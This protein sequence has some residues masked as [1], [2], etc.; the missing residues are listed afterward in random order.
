MKD[1]VSTPASDPAAPYCKKDI[2]VPEREKN[3][4]AGEGSGA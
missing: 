4:G 2:E 3:N 1:C